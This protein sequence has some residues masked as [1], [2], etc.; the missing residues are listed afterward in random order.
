MIRSLFPTLS[1][2]LLSSLLATLLHISV[3]YGLQQHAVTA[4]TATFIGAISGAILNYLCQYHA[5][6]RSTLPHRTAAVR[7]LLLVCTN[8][9]LN[10]LLYKGL[11][12]G[13]PTLSP[14]LL[15]ALTSASL[16]T[17]NLF[18]YQRIIFHERSC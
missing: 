16:A 14:L 17:I 3:F 12:T 4:Q 2:S 9:A 5:V 8:I 1:A 10:S 6:Y 15:Q 13:L 18:A 7:Y 11:A